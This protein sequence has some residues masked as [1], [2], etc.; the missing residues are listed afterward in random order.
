MTDHKPV[1]VM[2]NLYKETNVIHIVCRLGTVPILRVCS[3]SR[4]MYVAS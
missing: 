4:I 2:D 1:S 3:P